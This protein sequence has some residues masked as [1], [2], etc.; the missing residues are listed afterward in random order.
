MLLYSD[1]YYDINNKK[2][3][4]YDG[5]I[6]INCYTI[7]RILK[8]IDARSFDEK[9]L[10][11]FL[12][13]I[14]QASVEFSKHES[15]SAKVEIKQALFKTKEGTE[16]PAHFY[17][18]ESK[19]ILHSTSRLP[20]KLDKSQRIDVPMPSLIKKGAQNPKTIISRDVS[21]ITN[22]GRTMMIPPHE[23]GFI[24]YNNLD[25]FTLKPG[26]IAYNYNKNYIYNSI[27]QAYLKRID[28]DLCRELRGN[29]YSYILNNSNDSDLMKEIGNFKK[30]YDVP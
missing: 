16:I 10:Y 24:L 1:I 28:E 11:L 29:L 5:K 19:N 9:N 15:K 23:I 8:T 22:T 30:N 26:D 4:V 27:M 3:E 13:E 14:R 21:D 6:Y 18:Q 2:I 25:I 17:Y 12:K 20:E 7:A